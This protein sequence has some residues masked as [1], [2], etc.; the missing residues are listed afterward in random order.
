M[1][2]YALEIK[3]TTNNHYLLA[4]VKELITFRIL[5]IPEINEAHVVNC[6]I[7]RDV[8]QFLDLN[9]LYNVLKDRL[10]RRSYNLQTPNTAIF[11]PRSRKDIDELTDKIVKYTKL[12]NGK[13]KE[14]GFEL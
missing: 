2:L 1:D 5:V 9:E 13:P 8:I 3:D 12:P 4:K 11:T 10:Y 14:I 6:G 7:D